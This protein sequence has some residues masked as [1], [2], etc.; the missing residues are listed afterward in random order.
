MS[1]SQEP[2]PNF[3][4]SRK[5][6]SQIKYREVNYFTRLRKGCMKELLELAE[7]REIGFDGIK[8]TQ[9]RGHLRFSLDKQGMICPLPTR[10]EFSD[11]IGCFQV[12]P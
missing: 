10:A 2:L 7:L 11:K 5:P 8:L 4:I 1:S 9:E 12:T 3:K 6:A